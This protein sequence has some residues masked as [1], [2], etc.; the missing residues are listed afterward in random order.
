VDSTIFNNEFSSS[1]IVEIDLV[2]D[3][4]L[5]TNLT[6]NNGDTLARNSDYQDVLRH[7]KCITFNK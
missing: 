4:N 3:K 2:A 7:N 1:N 5:Y 6:E